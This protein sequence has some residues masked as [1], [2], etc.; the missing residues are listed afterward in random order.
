[1][2]SLVRLAAGF[3]FSS[4]DSSLFL[5]FSSISGLAAFFG[6]SGISKAMVL[7]SIK[8]DGVLRIN[9]IILLELIPFIYYSVLENLIKFVE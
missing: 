9:L 3:D 1:M 6:E 4:E 5:T 2:S 7:F 8:S